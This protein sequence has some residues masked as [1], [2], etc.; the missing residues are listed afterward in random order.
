M[1]IVLDTNILLVSVSD[2][3]AT[4]WLFDAFKK[5][6]FELAYTTEILA[7]YEEQFSNHWNTKIAEVVV[8]SSLEL[9][10]GIA[11]TVHY[12]LNL[13]TYDPDDNKFVDCAFASNADYLV[14]EDNDFDVLKKIDFP[15]IR[16]LTLKD[17]KQILLDRNLLDT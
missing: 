10:N 14:T 17:F 6:K 2:K 11:T 3:S 1:R 5:K 4:H 9:P 16:V 8:A 12:Q 13:I 7:E 15:L